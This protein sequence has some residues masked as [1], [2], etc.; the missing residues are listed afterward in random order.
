MGTNSRVLL[1]DA[2]ERVVAE[3]DYSLVLDPEMAEHARR[4]AG[5]LRDDRPDVESLFTLAQFM[6]HRFR[7]LGPKGRGERD[8]AFQL[9]ARCLIHGDKP[10]PRGIMRDV[11]PL[12]IDLAIDLL[13]QS[14]QARKPPP[15]DKVVD[16]WRRLE[17]VTS[18]EYAERAL[19]LANLRIALLLRYGTTLDIA[20]LDEAISAIRQAVE[21]A[22]D[23][24]PDRAAYLIYLGE[25]LLMRIKQ[26][27]APSDASEIIDVWREALRVLPEDSPDRLTVLGRLGV[28]LLMR[29]MDDETETRADLDE[30]IAVL[31]QAVRAAPAGHPDRDKYLSNLGTALE[32]RADVTENPAD[33]EEA[34]ATQ[35]EAEEAARLQTRKRRFG[36]RTT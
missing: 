34:R 16:A 17:S 26:R 25:T 3:R 29:F 18:D 6:W 8:I 13:R 1:A 15:A 36:R 14:A 19:V 5:S 22:A 21:A 9:F 23:D 33:R 35:Q 2:V 27:E 31:R 24:D 12:S 11:V 20:D 7:A 32:I 30:A 10:L 28:A 4:L